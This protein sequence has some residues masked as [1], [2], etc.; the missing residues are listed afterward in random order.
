MSA[1]SRVA[2]SV[3]PPNFPR[4]TSSLLAL[5]DRG[6]TLPL[7]LAPHAQRLKSSPNNA[8][9]PIVRASAFARNCRCKG[10]SM[11]HSFKNVVLSP[12]PED[13]KVINLLLVT[14]TAYLS[15]LKPLACPCQRARIYLLGL[16]LPRVLE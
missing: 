1:K 9:G 5:P 13:D 4:L 15:S 3:P 2:L 14:Y 11:E 6:T 16:F 8:C 10:M 12:P 7:T